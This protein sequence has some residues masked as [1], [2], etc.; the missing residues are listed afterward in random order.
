M[1]VSSS[2]E[3]KVTSLGGVGAPL[4]VW[5][6]N[7]TTGRHGT[8]STLVREGKRD[9]RGTC[10]FF[11][12]ALHPSADYPAACERSKRRRGFWFTSSITAKIECLK[13]R[14][15]A[16]VLTRLRVESALRKLGKGG[17]E[18][19]TDRREEEGGK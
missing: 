11:H 2:V 6:E 8:R 3:A 9:N 5:A 4:Y 7:L 10:L 19:D 15:T 16:L 12:S 17:L 1:L 18:G 13:R 14:S